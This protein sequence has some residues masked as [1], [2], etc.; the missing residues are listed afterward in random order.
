[1]RQNVA[2][3]ERILAAPDFGEN[4]GIVPEFVYRAYPLGPEVFFTETATTTITA[5][6]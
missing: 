6:I 4:F 2:I 3:S 1:M 5:A